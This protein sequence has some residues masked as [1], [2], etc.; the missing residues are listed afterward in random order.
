MRPL[1]GARPALENKSSSFIFQFS[2]TY[3]ASDSSI[4]KDIHLILSYLLPKTSFYFPIIF[5]SS[6]QTI[7]S[8]FHSNT[9]FF[10][11]DEEEKEIR[12]RQ[13]RSEQILDESRQK[14]C[15]TYFF[16]AII[17]YYLNAESLDAGWQAIG[18]L[19]WRSWYFF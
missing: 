2:S 3:L 18:N 13:R 10:S 1:I 9:F 11:F 5:Q 7:L 19:K 8:W 16:R 6:C 12:R 14:K 17:V 15:R 4:T